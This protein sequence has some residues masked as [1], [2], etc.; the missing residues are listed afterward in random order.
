MDRLKWSQIDKQ[1]VQE[2][3]VSG[4]QRVQL[5]AKAT[6]WS[7]TGADE[8]PAVAGALV[9]IRPLA[10]LLHK[11]D[12]EERL[13]FV[14]PVGFSTKALVGVALLVSAVC[15]LITLMATHAITHR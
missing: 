5:I 3:P 12:Q 9:H 8:S 2:V 6:G 14:E 13:P 7:V 4:F 1:L 11:G 10:V 15:C